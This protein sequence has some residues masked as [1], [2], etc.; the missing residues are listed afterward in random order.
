M[1]PDYP[2]SK[3]TTICVINKARLSSRLRRSSTR[4]RWLE[5]KTSSKSLPVLALLASAFLWP[6]RK[7]WGK[8]KIVLET[9]KKLDCFARI[10][11]RLRLLRRRT[12]RILSRISSKYSFPGYRKNQNR[13]P[14]GRPWT[15]CAKSWRRRTTTT[16]W[17]RKLPPTVKLTRSF[18]NSLWTAPG[19]K[20]S[21][22]EFK[23]RSL[24]MRRYKSTRS[25]F[26]IMWPESAHKVPEGFPPT[27][28]P[29]PS[30]R[31]TIWRTKAI[32]PA[33]TR[34]LTQVPQAATRSPLWCPETSRWT[35]AGK[36]K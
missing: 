9:F 30:S 14:K 7:Q 20:L 22:L 23:T 15:N 25:S 19:T 2:I 21:T 5:L 1:R 36:T 6:K 31:W 27:S 24:I 3:S 18:S 12:R 26:P 17:W 34:M 8:K 10:P 16:G 28:R 13:I 33:R 4:T 11:A 29:L 32:M 35:R